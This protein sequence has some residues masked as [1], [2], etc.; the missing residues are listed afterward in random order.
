MTRFV[1]AGMPAMVPPHV[2]PVFTR[3]CSMSVRPK[4][5]TTT[6]IR[7]TLASLAANSCASMTICTAPEPDGNPSPQPATTASNN[8]T[9]ERRPKPRMDV[10]LSR[11]GG[12]S[13]MWRED[14]GAHQIQDIPP[15]QLRQVRH[16]STELLLLT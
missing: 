12:D 3:S 15:I 10:P 2:L 4:P 6:W 16:P 14:F 8:P 5:E 1:P 7:V 13:L 9:T 11:A